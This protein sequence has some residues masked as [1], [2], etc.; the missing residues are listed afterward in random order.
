MGTS[1]FGNTP[2]LTSTVSPLVSSVLGIRKADAE[3]DVSRSLFFDGEKGELEHV[4][5][6]PRRRVLWEWMVR[7]VSG[8]RGD[9]FCSHLVDVADRFDVVHLLVLLEDFVHSDNVQVFGEKLQQ[10]FSAT[11][12]EGED[13]FTFISR[14]SS[15]IK[16]IERLNEI[17]GESGTEQIKVPNFIVVWKIFQAVRKYPQFDF[18]FRSKLVQKPREW[19]TLTPDSLVA[20]LNSYT[21]NTRDLEK[22]EKEGKANFT[23]VGPSR[24]M[25]KRGQFSRAPRGVCRSFFNTGTCDFIKAGFRCKFSHDTSRTG[26]TAPDRLKR[27]E[28]LNARLPPRSRPPSPIRADFSGSRRNSFSSVGSFSS[29][30]SRGSNSQTN[31]RQRNLRNSQTNFQQTNQRNPKH[32]PQSTPLEPARL[33]QR[34]AQIR[35]RVRSMAPAQDRTAQIVRVRPTTLATERVWDPR[36]FPTQ[37]GFRTRDSPRPS[38]QA[39][40]EKGECQ[41]PCLHEKPVSGLLPVPLLAGCGFFPIPRLGFLGFPLV[42]SGPQR[43]L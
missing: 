10:F 24:G 15:G 22:T 20:E 5:L 30:G 28:E 39:R 21:T 32:T 18:F 26:P 27:I 23:A 43:V 4:S 42:P 40:S 31:F 41:L 9:L 25:A 3:Q 14:L 8:E 29:F 2:L 6:G 13:I 38:S 16:D 36:L 37:G 7:S 11:P 35:S 17:V 12:K 34:L 33:A 1:L 19:L